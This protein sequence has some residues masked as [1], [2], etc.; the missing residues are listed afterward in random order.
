MKTKTENKK[1]ILDLNPLQNVSIKTSEHIKTKFMQ[2]NNLV[3]IL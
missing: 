3:C 1:F 2:M